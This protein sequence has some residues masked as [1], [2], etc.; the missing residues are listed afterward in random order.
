MLNF[1]FGF[2][3]RIRRTHYFLGALVTNLVAGAFDAEI[4]W[5]GHRWGHWRGGDYDFI[6]WSMAP[7]LWLTAMVV[8][9]ACFWASMALAA[10]RWH[11][12]GTTGWLAL[13]SLLPGIRFI[14]FLVLCLVPPTQGPNA[15]GPDPRRTTAA[16]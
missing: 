16:A 10:K 14:V 4:F 15:Y 1:I 7:G 8:G 13:L 9:I 11:D 5:G 2:H 12:M 3:G 6:G